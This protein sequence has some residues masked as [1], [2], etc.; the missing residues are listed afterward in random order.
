[1]VIRYRQ[2]VEKSESI[3]IAPQTLSHHI[4]AEFVLHITYEIQTDAHGTSLA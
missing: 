3:H 4:R 2:S 1:M